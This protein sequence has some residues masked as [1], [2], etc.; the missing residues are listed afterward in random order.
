MNEQISAFF[1]FLVE[2]EFP[3]LYAFIEVCFMVWG[4]A[5][6]F[7]GII[8]IRSLRGLNLSYSQMTYVASDT[9]GAD[10]TM[11]IFAG[12]MLMSFGVGHAM[13]AN[14]IY[15][16]STSFQPYSQEIFRSISCAS[17]ES[18]GCLSYDLGLYNEGSWHRSL[19]NINFFNLFTSVIQLS[20]AF[21]YGRGWLNVSKLASPNVARTNI[22]AGGCIVQIVVGAACM[23]PLE[24][25]NLIT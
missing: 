15:I 8:L 10:V 1:R 23:H 18:T 4:A 6:F 25:W 16:S 5:I 17:G 9:S 24:L 2:S 12:V 3:I 14:T 20:G 22:T 11:K 13:I 21:S 7:R 19:I